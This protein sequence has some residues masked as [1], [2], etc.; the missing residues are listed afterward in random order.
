MYH[1]LEEGA[2]TSEIRLLH[3]MQ[4]CAVP[5]L[6]SSKLLETASFPPINATYPFPLLFPRTFVLADMSGPYLPIK[7]IPVMPEWCHCAGSCILMMP[8][9]L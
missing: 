1:Q 4:V 6:E 9:M 3:V 8:C 7:S 5:L 2:P